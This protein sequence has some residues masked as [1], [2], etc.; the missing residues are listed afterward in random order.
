MKINYGIHIGATSSFI[1][2]MEGGEPIVI[3]SDTLKDS[4]PSFV[5]INKRKAIQVGD[6]ALN[7][8]KGQFW[9][10]LHNLVTHDYNSFAGFTRTLGSDTK[11]YSSNAD[12]SFSSEELVAEIIK[13]L[14]SF[15]REDTIRAA[16]ITVPATFKINQIDAVRKAGKLAGIQQV[17]IIT[18]PEAAAWVY[19]MNSK[20]KDGFWLV[21]DFKEGTF[22]A[23]LLKV[24]DGIRQVIDTCLL[25][26]S[27]SPRDRG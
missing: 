4:I 9:K 18:E 14:K 26:T 25:Y 2:K 3:R 8:Y 23:A 27:P 21:F 11:Y 19:G 24:E 5:L 16:V 17:E 7:A 1:A 22:D 20:N 10:A 12:R 15:V 13:T 6:A